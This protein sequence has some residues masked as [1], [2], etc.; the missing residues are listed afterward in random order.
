MVKQKPFLCIFAH[1]DD[2]AFGPAGAI[3]YFAK[4]RDVHIVCV[5]RGDA[6]PKYTKHDP[7]NLAD[8]RYDE[9]LASAKILGVKDVVF[10]NFKDGSLCNNN[11]HDLAKAIE[12]EI[13]RIKPYSILTFDINGISGHLDHVAVA[14]T[15][16]YAF[17]RQSHAKEL[18]YF[19]DLERNLRQWRKD[20]FI[21][22]PPG[23]TPE[24]ADL[25][26]DTAPYWNLR[27]GAMYAHVSQRD[28]ADMILKVISKYPK[29][30]YF[31]RVTKKGSAV[32]T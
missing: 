12:A 5:T 6:D 8:R 13:N 11:Y 14:L 7:D 24:D 19:L 2:E 31:R 26:I 21:W 27:K 3:A 18:L 15:T 17:Y 23:F 1:P 28:D 30:E 9:L 16:T 32:R 20:Y 10:L 4:T 29:K 22:M 25:E